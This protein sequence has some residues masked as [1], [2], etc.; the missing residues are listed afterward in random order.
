MH[1]ANLTLVHDASECEDVSQSREQWSFE[2]AKQLS[3][4][5][6]FERDYLFVVPMSEMD[7][8]GFSNLLTNQ[9]PV[10][11]IDTR[12]YPDF[13]GL[14]KS[15]KS[16][17]EHFKRSRVEYVHAPVSWI[18]HRES[19]NTWT[20]RSTLVEGLSRAKSVSD[21]HGRSFLLL[22]STD[23]MKASCAEAFASLPG[24]EEHWQLQ[25]L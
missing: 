15:T 16:A 3:L 2:N 4:F 1:R 10:S 12:K 6:D 20:V 19:V 18:A 7:Y 11:I 25:A 23:E 22:I 13:F 24:F 17:L 14:Y 5:D 8:F 21:L 9:K